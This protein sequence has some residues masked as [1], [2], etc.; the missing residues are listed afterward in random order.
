MSPKLSQ[1]HTRA[2]ANEMGGELKNFDIK[3]AT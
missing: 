2:E 3:L 1:Q